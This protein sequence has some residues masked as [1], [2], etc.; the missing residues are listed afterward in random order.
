[1]NEWYNP[2]MLSLDLDLAYAEFIHAFIGSTQQIVGDQYICDVV[3]NN[4]KTIILKRL[5]FTYENYVTAEN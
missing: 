1:M 5:L 4:E 3:W 2:F